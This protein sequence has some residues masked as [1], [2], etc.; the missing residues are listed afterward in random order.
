MNGIRF[1]RQHPISK[2]IVDFYCHKAKLV[3]EI[4]GEIHHQK[5]QAEIDEGRTYEL[6]NLDLKIIRF[7][8]DEVIFNIE[9]V[10]SKILKEVFISTPLRLSPKRGE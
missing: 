4:D 7:T 2:F 9:K 5:H 6:E 1:R 8:N 3:I 10:L